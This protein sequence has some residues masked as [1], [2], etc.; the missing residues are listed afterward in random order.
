MNVSNSLRLFVKE[1]QNEGQLIR[2]ENAGARIE[3][4]VVRD[5]YKV[6][7]KG[8]AKWCNGESSGV[9]ADDRVAAIRHQSSSSDTR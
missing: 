4:V 6:G 7:Q 9:D 8:V 1:A 5:P 3:R 2:R